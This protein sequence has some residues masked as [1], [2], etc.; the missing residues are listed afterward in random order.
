ML[1]QSPILLPAD[2]DTNFQI[3]LRWTHLL[4]GTTW[5]GLLYFFNLIS[6]PLLPT[7]DPPVRGKLI[8][9]LLPRALW[10][11]RWG[12]VVTVAAGMTYWIIILSRDHAPIARTLVIWGVL[13]YAAFGIQ[14][15]LL[16]LPALTNNTFAFVLADLLVVGLAGH[17][18]MKLLPYPG[19]SHRAL[20]IAVGG[21]IGVFLMTNVWDI[22]W[23]AQSRFIAWCAANPGQPPPPEIAAALRRAQLVARSSFW[24]SFPMLF[25]MAAA[26]H[27]PFFVSQ[28]R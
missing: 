22:V 18:M 28:L 14:A 21:G 25:F 6:I 13:I 23:P 4:A 8:T 7:L 1:A 9:L 19:A 2:W 27:F 11:F 3:L 20:S 5:I 24:L 12:S 26:S 16:R 10:W 15:L 17:L